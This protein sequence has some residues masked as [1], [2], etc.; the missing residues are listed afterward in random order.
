MVKIYFTLR[1]VAVRDIL[2]CLA[3]R[4]PDQTLSAFDARTS[5]IADQC[6]DS[7]RFDCPMLQAAFPNPA[8]AK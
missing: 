4:F 1:A 2:E 6:T 8:M 3:H 7:F 5:S